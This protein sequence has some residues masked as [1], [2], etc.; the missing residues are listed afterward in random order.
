VEDALALQYLTEIWGLGAG[1]SVVSSGEAGRLLA[2]GVPVLAT[3]EATPTLMQEAASASARQPFGP[4]W[5]AFRPEGTTGHDLLLPPALLP[6]PD[7]DLLAAYGVTPSP[8]GA[9]VVDAPAGVD[10]TLIWQ[11]GDAGWPDGLNI[12]VRP[13]RAG[14]L[15]PDPAMPGA[16]LQ[17]D[18]P[19]PANGLGEPQPLD[20]LQLLDPYRFVHG[21]EADGVMVIL[22]RA[23]DGGFENVTELRLPLDDPANR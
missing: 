23:V 18:R 21:E 17:Q 20:D 7:G 15:I 22:Y 1:T 10:I 6:A 11:P 19:E 9:P 14:Q 5:I 16:I 8:R 12:S 2:R 4:D 3:W 13:T